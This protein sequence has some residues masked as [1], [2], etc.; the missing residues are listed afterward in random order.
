MATPTTPTPSELTL[1]P[2]EIAAWRARTQGLWGEP[3]ATPMEA[4]E[5]LG[6]VQSQEVYSSKLTP[7]VRAAPGPDGAFAPVEAVDELI[8]NGSVVR[9]HVLRTT[10]HTVPVGDLRMMLAATADR[11]HQVLASM[12]RNGGL[13]EDLLAR[14]DQILAEATAGGRHLA[15]EEAV[16]ALVEAGVPAPSNQQMIYIL[17]HAELE[18]AICSGTPRGRQQTYANFDERVPAGNIEREDA[19]RELA[20]RFFVSRGPAT[21]KDF[22]RW[23]SLKVAD[24][25]KAIAD[26]DLRAALIDGRV[27]Y[28]ESEPP[29]PREGGPRV[30]F[31]QGWDEMLCSYTDSRDWVLHPSVPRAD[32]PDRPRFNSAILLDG[33]L[34]GHWKATLTKQRVEIATYRLRGFTAAEI[35]AMRRGADRLRAWYQREEMDLGLDHA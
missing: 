29:G 2:G 23:G 27:C 24:A 30:D 9:T 11:V 13:A 19:L 32:F 25:K 35:A 26:L 18:A 3:R 12:T 20:R 14:C 4:F 17:M 21:L 6:A 28:F 31:V 5:H 8:E 7:A 10:W 16:E 33:Q 15:R 34:I 22:T 1:E